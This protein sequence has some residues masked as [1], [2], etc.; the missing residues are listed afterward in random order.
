MQENG[1]S[2]VDHPYQEANKDWKKSLRCLPDY[3]F[4]NFD[5]DLQIHLPNVNYTFQAQSLRTQQQLPFYY[6]NE[7]EE[8]IKKITFFLRFYFRIPGKKKQRET[9][10]LY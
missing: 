6:I 3:N 8:V 7:K 1:Y 9:R 4:S 2:W 10:K 5:F